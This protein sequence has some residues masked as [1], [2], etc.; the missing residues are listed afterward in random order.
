[1]THILITFH[2]KIAMQTVYCLQVIVDLAGGIMAVSI[3]RCKHLFC[4]HKDQHNT[5]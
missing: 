4:N 3:E 2:Q 5:V 1:M